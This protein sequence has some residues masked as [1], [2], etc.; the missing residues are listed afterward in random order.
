MAKISVVTPDLKRYAGRRKAYIWQT[1]KGIL[2]VRSRP[3]QPY[4]RS[5]KQVMSRRYFAQAVRA[6]QQLDAYTRIIYRAAC[7]G[8]GM[9]GYEFFIKI[10]MASHY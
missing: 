1:W 10:N 4:T 3:Q 2:Y 9:S 6:W 8:T 5:P 7:A